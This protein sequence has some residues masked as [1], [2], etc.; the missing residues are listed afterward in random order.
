MG[1]FRDFL[2]SIFHTKSQKVA[3]ESVGTSSDDYDIYTNAVGAVAIISV[4]EQIASLCAMAE[5][6]TYQDNKEFKGLEWHNLNVSPNVNQ[7]ATEFWKEYYSKLLYKGEVLVLQHG[8]QKIIA[9]G[10]GIDRYA[11]K[12]NVFT[13]VYKNDFTFNRSYTASEVFYVRY[14]NHQ[15]RAVLDDVL[16]VYNKLFN[17]A[18]NKYVKSG[19]SK[20]VIEIDAAPTGDT[21]FEEKYSEMMDRRLKNFNQ[22]KNATLTLFSGMRYTPSNAPSNTKSSNEITDIKS[23]FDGAMV[24]AAQMFKFPPQ[25]VLGEVSGIDDAIA[26]A[27][28]SCIDPLLNATSEEFSRKEFTAEEHIAGNYI[29]ADTTNIKHIDI[30][31]LAP[32]IEKLISS[33]FMNV[34]ET[35]EKAGLVPTGEEWAKVHFCTKNQEPISNLNTAGGGEKNE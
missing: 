16:S 20:S 25:L 31:S 4:I 14:S 18:S 2:E 13:G 21:D 23:L 28:T 9:D 35:R 22:A 34:D 5:L 19:G 11:L 3:A 30:F 15:V 29:A 27:L 1:S 7:S 17:E 10:F 26:L 24:R 32:N 6:K 33:A 12:E 8:G